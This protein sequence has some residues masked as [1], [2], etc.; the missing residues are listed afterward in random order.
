[1]TDNEKRPLIIKRKKV[2][3][4]GGHHG[5]AWKVAYADFVTA[6]MAFFMLMWL[7]NATTEQQRKGIADYFSPT[8]PITRISGGGDG[9]FGGDS[10]FSETAIAQNGT[11]GTNLRPTEGRQSL[12]LSGT[13]HEA[14]RDED[15]AALAALQEALTGDSM[16]SEQLLAH[17]QTRLTDEGLIIEIY[18]RPGQVI[19]DPI[20]G[21]PAPWLPELATAMASLFDTV[22]NAVA[23]A[24][25]VAAEPVVVASETRWRTST[26]RAQAFR[27]MLEA[28]GLPPRR[29]V[30]VTGH[31]DREAVTDN[32]MALRNERLEIILLRNTY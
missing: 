14:A 19:F 31:A 2:T 23:I 10:P 3:A 17:V 32:P 9:A 22:T 1:M 30:R 12:G 27:A 18:S 8:I 7:L 29:I 4:G 21:D 20:T 15:T 25:H 11:G 26:D 6:M 24:G 28:A 16:V 5:G 13:D